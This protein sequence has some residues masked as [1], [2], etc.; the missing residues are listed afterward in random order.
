M[1]KQ[2]ST[3]PLELWGHALTFAEFASPGAQFR[4]N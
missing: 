2:Q 4:G 3:T 1:M